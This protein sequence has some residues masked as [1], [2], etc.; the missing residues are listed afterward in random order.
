MG[1]TE[2]TKMLDN[3]RAWLKKNML[4]YNYP[5]FGCGTLIRVPTVSKPF[6]KSYCSRECAD[7]Y[8]ERQFDEL[9]K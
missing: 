9:N 4:G 5:C 8:V 1:F 7:R 3:M 6:P 2:M